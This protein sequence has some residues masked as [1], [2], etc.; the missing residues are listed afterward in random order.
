VEVHDGRLLAAHT[1]AGVEH[2]AQV[3]RRIA[4]PG[5]PEVVSYD[6]ERLVTT[7]SPPVVWR[8]LTA[9]EV[10]AVVGEVAD[11]LARA[12]ATGIVH[13]PLDRADVQGRPGA[14]LVAGWG[15]V[16]EGAPADDIVEVGR[17]L[18]QVAPDDRDLRVLAARAAAPNPPSMAGL[19]AAL[20]ALARPAHE[21]RWAPTRRAYL[22]FV[23]VGATV[24]IVAVGTLLGARPGRGPLTGTAT[25]TLPTTSIAPRATTSSAP[26]QV[27]AWNGVTDHNGVR[28]RVGRSGD[29][30]VLG[31]WD[32]DSID[33]P[34]VLRPAT[35]EVWSFAR[36]PTGDEPL[37]GVPLATVPGA[38]GARVVPAGR[39]DRLAV[40]DDQ[41]RSTT[42]L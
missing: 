42:L 40:L 3:L 21:H 39:C 33:T 2:A 23:A 38:V 17:L 12:H 26:P 29:V 30:V 35:G 37:A 10:A 20:R 11:V 16:H 15:R 8:G 7:L 18:A 4:G 1:G 32:C 5:A 25:S 6:G 9:A 34:S 28:W 14:V 13:G 41:G 22:G 24:A 27:P 31:D 19:A 36:W